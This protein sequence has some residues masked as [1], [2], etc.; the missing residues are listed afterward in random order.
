MAFLKQLVCSSEEVRFLVL[1]LDKYVK[2]LQNLIYQRAVHI[3][4][5]AEKEVYK[6]FVQ[7]KLDCIDSK[8]SKDLFFVLS[9]ER[10]LLGVFC[11][12]VLKIF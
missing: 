7:R 9:C 4:L 6:R 5:Y 3:C 11:L 12:D 2:R 10:F 1:F 8:I